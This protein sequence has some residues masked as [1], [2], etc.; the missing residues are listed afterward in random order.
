MGITHLLIIKTR[1]DFMNLFLYHQIN[2]QP[3]S[4]PNIECDI[5]LLIIFLHLILLRIHRLVPIHL[6]LYN[7]FT[8][9]VH[10]D[11]KLDSIISRYLLGCVLAAANLVLYILRKISHTQNL[12]DWNGS[13]SSCMQMVQLVPDPTRINLWTQSACHKPCHVA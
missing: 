13:I 1:D 10:K 12:H 2:T 7:H 4:Q 8:E 6:F 3:A 11:S 5:K 9:T